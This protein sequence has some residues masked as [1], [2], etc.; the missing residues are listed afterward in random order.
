ML[1]TGDWETGAIRVL[2]DPDRTGLHHTDRA[3]FRHIP[4][5]LSVHGSVSEWV[6]WRETN[7]DIDGRNS[8]V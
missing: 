4:P 2:R 5:L 8:Y 6:S 1:E 3:P 7:M